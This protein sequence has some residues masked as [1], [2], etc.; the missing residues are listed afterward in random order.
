MS[1]SPGLPYSY[2]PSF[3][4]FPD[5]AGYGLGWR[6][7]AQDTDLLYTC[8]LD[9]STLLHVW[10]QEDST[11]FAFD[12]Y[13]MEVV[14]P[15]IQRLTGGAPNGTFNSR[16]ELFPMQSFSSDQAISDTTLEIDLTNSGAGPWTPLGYGALG[17][18]GLLP[19]TPTGAGIGIGFGLASF[20]PP[21]GPNAS[22]ASY[23]VGFAVSA[24]IALT[25]TTAS[26][27]RFRW[28]ERKLRKHP[29]GASATQTDS[30]NP[31]L[32][33]YSQF[34]RLGTSVVTEWA[35]WFPQLATCQIELW[36]HSPTSRGGLYRDRSNSPQ[37]GISRNSTVWVP[38]MRLPAGVFR[39]LY[40]DLVTRR[41]RT[42]QYAWC[43]WDDLNQARSDISS[44]TIFRSGNYPLRV[45]GANGGIWRE[46][47]SIWIK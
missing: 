6:A 46:R 28:T 12:S 9:E 36:R 11:P 27:F 25:L 37:A 30:T 2:F 34:V 10:Q 18:Y 16:Y 21:T 39:A 22:I 45:A 13:R 4:T 42:L 8:V 17:D 35:A 44:E 29:Q 33:M 14:V 32:P 7:R 1:L 41:G 38:F 43:Y 26:A 24:A 15:S 40:S 20:A 19:R 23:A 31:L 5:A 3:V 47:N